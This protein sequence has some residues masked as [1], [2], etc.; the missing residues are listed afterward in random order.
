MLKRVK[1]SIFISILLLV[2]VFSP[3]VSSQI[4]LGSRL[5]VEAKNRW[6]SPNGDFAIGFFTRLSQY[7]IGIRISSG[8]VPV[9]KQQ[10]VWVAGG[11]LRVGDKSYFEL[12]KDGE[13]VLFDSTRGVIVW[14]SNTT[15]ASVDSAVL[16]DDGNFVLLRKTKDIV[17][18]SFD[19]PSD[20]LLPGQNLSASQVLRAASRNSIS[21]YYSLRIGVIGDLELKWENDVIYWRSTASSR[22]ALRAFLASNGSLQLFDQTSTPIWSVFS[23]D[24]GESD[25]KFR[26][27]RLDVDGN[28]RLHSWSKNSTSWKL[29]WQAVE[30]QCDVFATCGVTGICAFNETGFPVCKCP[31]S[32]SA[33]PSSKC[34][35]PYQQ[36]CKSGSSMVKLD[37]TSL[38]ATFPPNETI[39]S[40]VSSTQ[41]QNLC[42]QDRLC[43]AATYLNDGSANCRIK[44]T[45]YVSG[46]LGLSVASVSYV[47]RCND[48]IAVVPNLTKPKPL[49]PTQNTPSSTDSHNGICVSCVIKV[50]GGTII[51][52]IVFHI[53]LMGYWIYRR[54]YNIITQDYSAS[55]GDCP[56]PSGFLALSYGEVKDVTENLKHRIGRNTFKGVFLQ[57]QPVVV[58][59]YTIMNVDARK[60]RRGV[61]KL[62]SI[63]HRNLVRLEG[64]CCDASYRFL[65]HEYLTNGSL[66]KC[67]EDPLICKK[68]T[69]RKRVDLC[70]SVARALSYLHMGCREFIG[71][72]SLTCENVFLDE[73]LEAKVN[74]FGMGNFLGDGSDGSGGSAKDIQ[75]FGYIVLAV[76]SGDPKAN[77]SG[78]D[79]AYE[80]WVDGNMVE[81]VDKTIEDV[82]NDELERVLRIMFWCFQSDERM[83][84]TM[85]EIVNVLEGA[86]AVDP[87]PHPSACR[88]NM[89]EEG[90]MGLES[91][92]KAHK[93]SINYSM[94]EGG[95]VVKGLVTITLKC[96]RSQVQFLLGANNFKWPRQPPEKGRALPGLSLC[97]GGFKPRG[98]VGQKK[99]TR[100]IQWGE[101]QQQANYLHPTAA[102]EKERDRN[103]QGSSI[104]IGFIAAGQVRV[105][106]FPSHLSV[107][108]ISQKA[109]TFPLCLGSFKPVWSSVSPVKL[110]GSVNSLYIYTKQFNNLQIFPR[111]GI[112][113]QNNNNRSVTTSVVSVVTYNRLKRKPTEGLILAFRNP[114][115]TFDLDSCQRFFNETETQLMSKSNLK[116]KKLVL[117]S[118]YDDSGSESQ[119]ITRLIHYALAR[120][121]QELDLMFWDTY[122]HD[123][124]IV[125]D[126]SFFINTHFTLFINTH[127]THLKLSCKFAFPTYPISWQNL[128]SLSLS[129]MSFDEKFIRNILSGCPLL[130]TFKLKDCGG[131]DISE[132]S[133]FS[134][135]IEN[136]VISGNTL[137]RNGNVVLLDAP[138]ILSLTIRGS[139][140]LKQLL[141]VD[142][143][144]LLRACA[145]LDD[146]DDDLGSFFENEEEKILQRHMVTLEHVEKLNGLK[147]SGRWPEWATV[148]IIGLPIR[149]F[150]LTGPKPKTIYGL[151]PISVDTPKIGEYETN[152]DFVSIYKGHYSSHRVFSPVVSSQIPLGSR[153]SVEAKNHWV[154]QNG[155]FAIGFF[156]RLSQYGIGIRISSGLVPIEKQQVVWV[157]GGDLRVGDKSYFELTKDGE[158]VLFDSTRGVI[159]WASNT[160]NASVDSAVLQDDGNFVLLRK[161][162]DIVWQSFD[163]PSDTLLPGQN[164]SA[165]QVLRAASR[166]SISSYYSLRIDGSGGS[167]KDIQDFGYIVLAVLSGDPKANQSGSDLAYEKWVDGNMVEIVD[168]TIE[169]VDKDELERVLRIM[170]WCFQSDER[171]R[172]TM[173][174]IVNVLEGAMAV[175]PPPHPSAC[176]KNMFEEG[177]ATGSD[178]DV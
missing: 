34:L 21:S 91:S 158:L 156:T 81:I 62:G 132:L 115:P 103:S 127:F 12:T 71:H 70:I 40:Q 164:L 2:V 80:K 165:S 161:T 124:E 96:V 175:D 131:D 86:M 19:T 139:L 113:V 16:Q 147:L 13:L 144:S 76:L 110:Q 99:A 160:T 35:L 9:E 48:P 26:I 157:A 85:G 55:K 87:P 38:Y 135:S 105:L 10:V 98:L 17:W 107:C 7:G 177:Y 169:D 106:H 93:K 33:V 138:N 173:G 56:N 45:Q 77:Q 39:I 178:S 174:E 171:M 79:L 123:Y 104:R 6:V 11:D 18:Q 154:S 54:K 170:F 112:Q 141:L 15:N 90:I 78:S 151:G 22:K 1:V 163:T 89:F 53:G 36:S 8:L 14:A 153:L 119:L 37:H 32:L 111:R 172:P 84:P 148:I 152:K 162:K 63:H 67:L 58:K 142:V 50:G 59:D 121:V 97:G 133:I 3:V 137:F 52:F 47:K 122:A 4:P 94:D 130:K 114:S 100:R 108:G 31:F 69:W 65:V 41:C 140:L 134:P 117:H 166:N 83:R 43:T 49:N 136:L 72:G 23:E 5:S 44:T 74:E 29:V 88:K 116:I 155:D 60:F 82:D 75:D 150:G 25:I 168:K 73:N 146:A 24:H 30:N 46:Q 126:Q 129:K 118:S 20:T 128:K 68:L 176:R 101:Q 27:L 64:Y 109:Y 95:L 102:R 51:V 42:Q 120:N 143:T 61:M 149:R 92:R 28:L 125:L 145:S 159:V 57:N 66:V 167:A